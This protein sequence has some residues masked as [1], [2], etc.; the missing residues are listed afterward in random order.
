MLGYVYQNTLMISQANDGQIPINKDAFD[1]KIQ[2]NNY[3]PIKDMYKKII[4]EQK[5]DSIDDKEANDENS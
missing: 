5:K 1:E 2:Q 4:L 3:Q